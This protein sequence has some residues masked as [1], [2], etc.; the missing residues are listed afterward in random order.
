M[1]HINYLNTPCS[2][3]CLTGTTGCCK[4]RIVK[5]M[6]QSKGGNP[7]VYADGTKRYDY[8]VDC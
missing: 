8:P 4:V 6:N 7:Y 3:E 1:N 5:F 2:S